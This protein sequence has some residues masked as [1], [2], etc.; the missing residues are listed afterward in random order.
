MLVLSRK[1]G[2]DVV[3]VGHGVIRLVSIQGDKVRLGFDFPED[4]KIL[5]GEL[6]DRSYLDKM[7]TPARRE[8]AVVY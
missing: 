2:E 6:T 5:R 4:E 1:A 3:I 7:R 8:E